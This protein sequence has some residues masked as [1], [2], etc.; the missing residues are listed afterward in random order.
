MHD[1]LDPR[2]LVL[3]EA[4]QRAHSGYDVGTRE[5]DARAAAAANDLDALAAIADALA[6]L[7]LSNSWTYVEP[8]DEDELLALADSAPA[9]P[10]AEAEIPE[11]LRGAWLGRTVGNTMGKP[12]EGMSPEDVR[13]Y[14]TAGGDWPQTGYVNL[15]E[16][17]PAGVGPLHPSAPESAAGTF[18][19]VPR[20]DDIDWTI[21]ALFL[22]ERYGSALTTEDIAREWL[23]RLPFTQ[24]FT[25]ERAAYRNL[26]QGRPLSETATHVNPYREWIGALIRGDFFGYIHPGNPA[27]AA[28]AALVDARLS[29]VKNGIYG[30]QWAAALV[31]AAFATADARTA[32][33]SA[34][35]VVPAGSRLAEA[36]RGILDL[37]ASGADHDEALAWIA[38]HLGHYNWVHTINNA[39]IIAAGLLWGTTFTDAVAKT[40][41]GGNDTDSNGATVGSVYGALHG[42]A[43]IPAELV[44][45]THVHVRSAV[46]GFDS[47]TV[48]DL[49]ARTLAVRA[50]LG[51]RG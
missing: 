5:T 4:E 44:G 43:S 15:V 49:A 48:D 45:T 34:Q 13:T 36:T 25:A 16:P 29:H 2:D 11:R 1:V 8:D 12:V 27:A 7:P 18:T 10:I 38:L 33:E 22:H 31:A 23:D 19:D 50:Q 6:S 37:H 28:R 9:L 17:H 47:I 40:I 51:S 14:L 26:I 3:D 32:L 41:A 30:E 39:A 42:V 46:G 35:A 20:D 21:L 24:T